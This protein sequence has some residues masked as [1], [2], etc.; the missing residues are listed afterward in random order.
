MGAWGG[1]RVGFY[2]SPPAGGPKRGPDG[3]LV[4]DGC[5]RPTLVNGSLHVQHVTTTI[6]WGGRAEG[7]GRAQYLAFARDAEWSAAARDG[8][9]AGGGWG[10]VDM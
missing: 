9:A 1:P 3:C 8:G 5:W 7:R 10:R 6:A 2:G 4:S